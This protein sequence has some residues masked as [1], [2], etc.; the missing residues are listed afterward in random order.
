MP[1]VSIFQICHFKPLFSF[2]HGKKDLLNIRIEQDPGDHLLQSMHVI[3]MD[4]NMRPGEGKTPLHGLKLVV[5]GPAGPGVSRGPCQ[6]FFRCILLI[7]SSFSC[8]AAAACK[9]STQKKKKSPERDRDFRL[10]EMAMA[11]FGSCPGPH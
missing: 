10:T 6:G 4:M 11:S 5:A 2:L 9:S 1:H 8:F 7:P 3:N